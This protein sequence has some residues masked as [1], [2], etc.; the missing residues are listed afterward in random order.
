MLGAS[1]PR[2]FWNRFAV[3][4]RRILQA[5][6]WLWGRRLLGLEP[7]TLF[8]TSCCPPRARFRPGEEYSHQMI[9]CMHTAPALTRARLASERSRR[10]LTSDYT[11]ETLPSTLQICLSSLK[12][13]EPIRR[14]CVTSMSINKHSFEGILAANATAGGAASATPDLAWCPHLRS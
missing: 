13:V 2:G 5:F 7:Q 10:R 1:K 6:R 12:T 8:L 9:S 14:I 3:P 4:G 11:C